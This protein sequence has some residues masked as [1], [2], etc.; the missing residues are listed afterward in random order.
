MQA[1]QS[2]VRNMAVILLLA[3]FLE[4]LMPSKSM[5]GY[6]QLV[7]GLFV[8]SALLN[9]IANFLHMPLAWN[10]PAWTTTAPQD[11]PA[12]AASGQGAQLGRNAVV[13]QYREILQHQ[14]AALASSVKGV[15]KADVTINFENDGGGFADQPRIA[16]VKIVLQTANVTIKPVP[17]IV[18]DGSTPATAASQ[19]PL[20]Q[21]VQEKVATLMEIAPD[22]VVVQMGGGS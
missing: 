10:I 20:A 8:I 1:L 2:L 13:E 14:I 18:I 12:L 21:E 16:A 5:R 22:K 15:D 6:V 4:M 7:M 3:T 19:A 11:L 17:P 9:P